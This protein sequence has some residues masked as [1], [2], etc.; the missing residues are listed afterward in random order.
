[1]AVI[2]FQPR[3]AALVLNG[4]K[5][6]TIRPIGKRKIEAGMKLSLRRWED[7]PYRSKQVVLKEA[8]CSKVSSIWISESYQEFTFIVDGVRLN[9]EQ[10]SALCRADGFDCT[11]DLLDWFEKTHGLPFEGRLI[12]WL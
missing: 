1:M 8:V 3:F 6:Q 10:W 4:Q 7:K 5:Q 9:Q 12:Q 11:T 2:M